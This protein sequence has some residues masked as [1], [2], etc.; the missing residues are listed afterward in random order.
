MVEMS[1]KKT[2]TAVIDRFEDEYAVLL[3][4]T[5]ERQVVFPTAELPEGLCEGDYL[6]MDISYD[7]NATKRAMDES[8]RLLD[9]LRR[10]RP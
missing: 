5:K 2:T 6:R 1:N 10:R 4:G 3:V 9:E 8:T 7:K